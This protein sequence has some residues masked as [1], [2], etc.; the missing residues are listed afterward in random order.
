MG[1]ILEDDFITRKEM[2]WEYRD[3]FDDT[4][5]ERLLYENYMWS[6]LAM[7]EAGFEPSDFL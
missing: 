2:E 3:S 5:N 4:E 1:R 7:Y 6:E